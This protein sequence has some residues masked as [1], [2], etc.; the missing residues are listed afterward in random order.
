MAFAVGGSIGTLNDD[1]DET[2]TPG[3]G[4][5]GFDAASAWS[6]YGGINSFVWLTT[7]GLLIGDTAAP[8]VDDRVTWGVTP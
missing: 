4:D 5:G 3:N 2:V 8:S 7:N 1:V 6:T